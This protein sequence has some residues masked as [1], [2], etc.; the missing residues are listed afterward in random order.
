MNPN[1][2]NEYK[3]GVNDFVVLEGLHAIKHAY[4]F[5]AEIKEIISPNKQ[6][7][8][9]LAR[10]LAPDL[11][12]FLANN[13]KEVD[14]EQYKQVFPHN[15]HGQLAAIAKK[16]NSKSKPEGFAVYLE[17]PNSIN[18]LGAVVR[19]LAARGVKN[20]IVSGAKVSV[21]HKDALR[22][23]AGLLFALES[24]CEFKE[25]KDA[26]EFLNKHNYKLYDF[27][28]DATSVP[29]KVEISKNECFIFGTERDGLSKE[30]K[31]ASV[32]LK[33][34]MQE[35]VSSLNLATSVAAALYFNF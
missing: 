16:A 31:D 25:S 27:D 23:S 12:E 5:G 3:S 7:A 15:L 19:V 10:K 13:I 24:V 9:A 22:T 32:L 4:R 8:L 6:E 30:I 17:N 26:L 34:P 20:L 28:P 29:H 21:W 33:I 35:K 2:Y 14:K 18:N 11:L 1:K